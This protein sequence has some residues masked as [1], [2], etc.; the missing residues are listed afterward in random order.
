MAE[1]SSESGGATP[2]ER[3]ALER[4]A[5]AALEEQRRSRRW[6]IFFKSLTFLYLFVLLFVFLGLGSGKQRSLPGRH[7]Q[8][9]IAAA[10]GAG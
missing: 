6:G 8:N 7:L 9:G 2:W 3:D 4:L 1:S 5:R 10:H